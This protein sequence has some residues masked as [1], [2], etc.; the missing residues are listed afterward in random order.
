MVPVKSIVYQPSPRVQGLIHLRLGY[1]YWTKNS[2]L[3]CKEID[4]KVQHCVFSRGR[5]NDLIL[6]NW[7]M[8]ISNYDAR[9]KFEK[10]ERVARGAAS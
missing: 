8:R 6:N 2:P 1:L 10:H 7:F 9:G 5:G 4:T 3:R